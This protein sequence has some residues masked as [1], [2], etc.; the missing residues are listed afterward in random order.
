MSDMTMVD[1]NGQQFTVQL[2][3][4]KGRPNK[5]KTIKEIFECYKRSNRFK[6]QST[7]LQEAEK[8][9]FRNGFIPFMGDLMV[10]DVANVLQD[11]VEFREKKGIRPGTLEKET[12]TLKKAIH[13]DRPEW[14]KPRL[15]Y[16][17]EPREVEISFLV[18]DV[19]CVIETV[20]NS[21]KRYGEEY[22][23]IGMVAVLTSMRLKDV[24][25]LTNEKI[26]RKNWKIKF[27]Q[28]KVKNLLRARKSNKQ[29]K[30]VRLDVHPKLKEIFKSIPESKTGV[31]WNIPS[32]GAVTT[33]YRRAF[34]KCGLK[35]SF[36]SFRHACATT[37]LARGANIKVVQDVLGHSNINTTQKYLHAL[38][39]QKKSAIESIWTTG[40]EGDNKND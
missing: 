18:E 26:D 33:A 10:S 34:K 13:E 30:P 11:Y 25:E 19:E 8:A 3:P 28:S 20:V 35:G 40:M 15:R 1:L 14:V 5:E 36:H 29:S 6:D 7:D 12:R 32:S 31:L 39:S 17:N 21:S 16:S 27:V 24:C 37:L 2:K 9:Y 4:K 23:K 22:L 38:D